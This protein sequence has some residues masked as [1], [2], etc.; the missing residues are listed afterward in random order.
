MGFTNTIVPAYFLLRG[1]REVVEGRVAACMDLDKAFLDNLV[2]YKNVFGELLLSKIDEESKTGIDGDLWI[3]VKKKSDINEFEI[4]IL[5]HFVTVY[6]EDFNQI[7][8]AF[9][10][11]R[12]FEVLKTIVQALEL[13]SKVNVDLLKEM[14]IIAKPILVLMNIGGSLAYRCNKELETERQ[15]DYK[16]RNHYHYY[17]PYYDE[18]IKGLMEHP[19]VRLAIYTSIKR[20]N[21]M[22]LVSNIFKSPKIKHLK[23]R[24]FDI[25]D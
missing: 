20:Y 7:V 12:E 14:F 2:K 5:A 19:R 3:D 1:S 18:L 24:V 23:Y 22:P 25:F 15:T 16:V 4:S 17:R 13:D 10:T 21:A 11:L 6:E 8:K 9:T